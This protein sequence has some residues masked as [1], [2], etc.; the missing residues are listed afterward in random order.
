MSYE[1]IPV[2]L[3]EVLS[4]LNPKPG[5][6]IID[7]T[8]GGA[9]YTSAISAAVGQKGRVISLDADQ[10]AI[11]NATALLEEKGVK[12]VT[13]V[14]ENFKNVASVVAEHLAGQADGIV[15]DLGLSSAQLADE[16]RGFSFQGERPLDMAFGAGEAQSTQHLLNSSSLSDLTSIFREL[17]EEPQ[18]YKLAKEIITSRKVKPLR[19]TKDLV[20]IILKIT[21]PRYKTTGIHPATKAFQALRLAT[22]DELGS[23][24]TAL[25]DSL[26]ILKIGGRIAVV[27]FHSGEDRI[28]KQ[29]MKHESTDCICP[30]TAPVC[31]CGHLASIKP[32]TKKPLIP[33]SEETENNPRARSAKLRG[34]EKI[35]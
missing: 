18:A 3:P 28:V 35:R 22:N 20:D 23:L 24:R 2:M 10:M 7:C 19:T 25:H 21:P 17:G 11:A 16:T 13:L 5:Q 33:A 34:A 8:L 27:S 6:T 1:H 30:S 4:L 15:F 32:L 9:G 26:E 12:N 29:W 14:H 31:V